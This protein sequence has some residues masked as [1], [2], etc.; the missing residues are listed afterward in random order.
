MSRLLVCVVLA[1]TVPL[2]GAHA[3]EG[4]YRFPAIHGDTVVFAAEGDLW[5]VSSR[6]GVARR[7][8]CRCQKLDPP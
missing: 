8:T 7:L 4:Y 1:L 2:T 3:T 6:G 5:T